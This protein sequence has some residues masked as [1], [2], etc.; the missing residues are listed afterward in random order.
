MTSPRLWRLGL[1]GVLLLTV[2]VRLAYASRLGD[3]IDGDEAVSGLMAFRIAEG[4]DFPLYQWEAH[5]SGTLMSYLGALL[6]LVF[7]PTPFVFRFSALPLSLVATAAFAAAARTLWGPGPALAAALWVAVG[8]P[9]ALGY[10]SQVLSAYPEIL[11]FGGLA[12]WLGARLG[13]REGRPRDWALLGAAGGFGVYSQPLVLP[14][15]VAILWA[16]RRHGAGPSWRESRLLG[17]G[18]LVGFSPFLVYNA[19]YRGA[20]VLRLAGRVLNLSRAEVTQASNLSSLV[21][22]KAG[23]YLEQLLSFPRILA[24]NVPPFLGLPWWGA[25]GLVALVAAGVF[26][27]RGRAAGESSPAVRHPGAWE[28]GR[29]FVGWSGLA[30]IL[31]VWPLGL[32]RARHLFPLYLPVALGLA[33]LWGRLAGAVRVAAM[34]G[35]ALLLLSNLAGARQ[36]ARDVGPRMAGLLEALRREGVGFVYTD[37]FIAYPL[38][39]LS[40]EAVL[41]SPAAG[42]V[43]VDRFPP[44]TE[45]VSRSA[46]PAYVFLR[47]TEPSAVFVAEMRRAGGA[48]RHERVGDFDLYLPDRHVRPNELALLKRF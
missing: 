6:F 28:L 17:A 5:Y 39:F 29:A 38:V 20:S 23:A 46:R 37:Y 8:P 36:Q 22:E 12:L 45:A 40:R 2:A 26:L 18:F 32:D 24:A 35:L 47:D 48:F 7:E 21:A 1:G 9:L 33:A 3:F 15:F 13:V 34:G 41:A 11:A 30:T 14:V 10:S 16:L 31:F 25:W 19:A 43:N 44:Y 27:P 4:R 42:P